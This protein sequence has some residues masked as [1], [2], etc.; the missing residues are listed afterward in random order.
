MSDLIRCVVMTGPG[1][2]LELRRVAA[3]R[4]APG[5]AVLEMVASEV[6]GTDVHLF[7]GRLA[8]VPWPIVPG[9]VSVGR[10]IETGGGAGTRA[11]AGEGCT[12]TRLCTEKP[13]RLHEFSRSIRSWLRSPLQRRR[14][15]TSWRKSLSAA[16]SSTYGS[17]IHSPEAVQPPREH[18]AWTWGWNFAGLGASLPDD[19]SS[20]RRKAAGGGPRAGA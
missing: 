4:A 9:H 2:P 18:S 16:P 3:P 10:V 17:G 6:C 14:A 8:G 15:S 1:V 19:G 13:L 20:L 12:K 11:E 7:H 5:G